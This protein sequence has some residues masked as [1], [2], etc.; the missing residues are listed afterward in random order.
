MVSFKPAQKGCVPISL[1][2]LHI[3]YYGIH[4]VSFLLRPKRDMNVREKVYSGE[5]KESKRHWGFLEQGGRR[6]ERLGCPGQQSEGGP[7]TDADNK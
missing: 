5:E 7:K 2:F 1:K 6:R 3:L 4:R